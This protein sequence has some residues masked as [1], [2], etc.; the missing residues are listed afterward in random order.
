MG[1]Y[2]VQTNVTQAERSCSGDN[3]AQVDGL[4][5]LGSIDPGLGYLRCVW[6]GVLKQ[7]SVLK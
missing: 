6:L 2:L 4:Y 3:V 5:W 7:A 1:T